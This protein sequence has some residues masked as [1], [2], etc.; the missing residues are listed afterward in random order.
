M[1]D[2]DDNS[3]KKPYEK[4]SFET[5]RLELEQP[6]LDASAPDFGNGGKWGG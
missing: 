2:M 5:I 6:L 3:T 4:P 1:T